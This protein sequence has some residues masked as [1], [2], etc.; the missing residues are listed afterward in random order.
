MLVKLLAFCVG[1]NACL[2]QMFSKALADNLVNGFRENLYENTKCLVS[3]DVPCVPLRKLL[4]HFLLIAAH[5]PPFLK[6]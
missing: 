2:K 6:F 1:P 5:T 4:A 3:S